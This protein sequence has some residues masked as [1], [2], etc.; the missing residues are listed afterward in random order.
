MR[1]GSRASER[2]PYGSH[3][4]PAQAQAQAQA[5]YQPT[6]ER[7]RACVRAC[8]RVSARFSRDLKIRLGGQLSRLPAAFEASQSPAGE[9]ACPKRSRK[10]TE[11]QRLKSD[12][13]F[14]PPRALEGAG[15]PVH[16]PF[17]ERRPDV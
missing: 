7:A 6:N 12:T 1:M 3:A 11:P 9:N 2:A 5:G 17:E 14:K 13:S 10:K 16:Y 8:V 15:S 4:R